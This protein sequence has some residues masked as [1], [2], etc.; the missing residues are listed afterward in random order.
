MIELVIEKEMIEQLAS[1]KGKTLKSYDHYPWPKE[2]SNLGFM[3]LNFSNFVIDFEIDYKAYTCTGFS[4]KPYSDE[5][6]VITCAKKNAKDQY[7]IPKGW[8][9]RRYLVGEVVS[10]VMIVRDTIELT[11]GDT[12]VYDNAVVI[13]TKESTYTISKGCEVDPSLYVRNSDKIDVP[14]SVKTEK[15]N[16]SDAEH[17][18]RA[19]IQRDFIFL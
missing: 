17:K 11:N 12:Y 2:G 15:S 19:N 14:Y 6:T 8:N 7:T 13:K 10:E 1:M 3:R 18:I 16:F 4:G 5:A 9:M